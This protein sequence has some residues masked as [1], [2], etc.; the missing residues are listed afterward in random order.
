MNETPFIVLYIFINIENHCSNILRILFLRLKMSAEMHGN[1]LVRLL[2]NYFKHTR[3][4]HDQS[5]LLE[6]IFFILTFGNTKK[7]SK[8]R[9]VIFYIF[10]HHSWHKL[11]SLNAHLYFESAMLVWKPEQN[12]STCLAFFTSSLI[13]LWFIWL[14]IMINLQYTWPYQLYAR[15]LRFA[16]LAPVSFETNMK[17]LFNKA[18]RILVT[19]TYGHH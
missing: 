6:F 3:W 14:R 4:I 7:H 8:W 17:L 9:L 16:C 10:S 1:K 2:L 18:R 12:L 19:Y 11:W 13:S 15:R 5:H